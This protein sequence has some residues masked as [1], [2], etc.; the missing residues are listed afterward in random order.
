MSRTQ[1][2]IAI[3]NTEKRKINSLGIQCFVF[4]QKKK[5][6]TIFGNYSCHNAIPT[7]A[8]KPQTNNKS[9]WAA[10]KMTEEQGKLLHT[11]ICS[12]SRWIYLNKP[13]TVHSTLEIKQVPVV[14]SPLDRYFLIVPCWL[15]HSCEWEL[16][17]K[18]PS[19]QHCSGKTT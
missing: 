19:K 14:A 12:F 13:P 8:K 11:L 2:C 1:R 18:L 4:V 17:C 3:A 9:D 6:I 5:K 10:D 15:P 16:D 7:P